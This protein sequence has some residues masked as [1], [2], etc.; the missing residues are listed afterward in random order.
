MGVTFADGNDLVISSSAF[1][2][3]GKG[4]NANGSIE[5]LFDTGVNYLGASFP[6]AL[7]FDL[8]SG[9]S[10][11]GNTSQFAG[12]G[13]GF[14]AG[15]LSDSA[16]DRA[17]MTDWVDSL[18]FVDNLYV[19]TTAPVPEPSTILLLS[20]GLAGVLWYGRKRKTA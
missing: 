6:G 2:L 16:F 13:T 18:A 11:L 1:S 17:V 10:F 4:V 12:S 20:I 5:L 9:T 3:D 14:F 15:F 19:A 8:Y 7:Q